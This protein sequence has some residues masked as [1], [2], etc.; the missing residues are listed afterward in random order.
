M[1]ERKLALRARYLRR[2][3]LKNKYKKSS[4]VASNLKQGGKHY[5]K[6]NTL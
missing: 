4:G 3:Y 6:S 5:E 1:I 2:R